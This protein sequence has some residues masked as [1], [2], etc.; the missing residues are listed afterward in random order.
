MQNIRPVFSFL[1][2]TFSVI[3][4]HNG[5][6]WEL[7]CSSDVL[8][9]FT[10]C[11]GGS[12]ID[13]CREERVWT[14]QSASR[15]SFWFF[16]C[17]DPLRMVV[18]FFRLEGI[19]CVILMGLFTYPKDIEGRKIIISPIPVSDIMEV[20]ISFRN[21]KV[22][23]GSFSVRLF[24]AIILYTSGEPELVTPLFFAFNYR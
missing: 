7:V 3:S 17:M 5:T 11:D 12:L 19:W 16:F 24:V 22:S 18:I 6:L 23:W 14:I 20:G 21:Q 13:V 1:P 8:F 10:Q 9:P 15:S 4:L 2:K